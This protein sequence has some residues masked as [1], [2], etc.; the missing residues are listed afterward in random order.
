M[1]FTQLLPLVVDVIVGGSG[2]TTPGLVTCSTRFPV[3]PSKPS[4]AIAYVV[5]AVAAVDGDPVCRADLRVERQ[6]ALVRPR[7]ARLAVVVARDWCE[8]VDRA[9]RVDGEQR[10]EAASAG[11]D[12][13]GGA[14]RGCPL[15]PDRVPA[16]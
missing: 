12:Q 16:R 8:R 2:G 10:V 15:P 7:A 6:R 1:T 11:R 5:P 3:A 9:A 13:L 14:R 4:T